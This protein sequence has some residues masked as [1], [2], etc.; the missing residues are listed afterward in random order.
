[1][2]TLAG[3]RKERVDRILADFCEY[4]G[5]SHKEL[6]NNNKGKG[7][8]DIWK[9]RRMLV[10]ILYDNTDLDFAEIKDILNYKQYRSVQ[11]HYEK[12]KEELSD[13]AYGSEKTKLSY[14]LLLNH[15]NL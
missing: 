14:N 3:I 15:L 13:E 8:N 1:M 11:Y 5:V 4:Y 10:P 6:L 2:T 9:W 7:A 12:L